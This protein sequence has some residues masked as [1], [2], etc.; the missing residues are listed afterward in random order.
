M[1]EVIKGAPHLPHPAF[2][3]DGNEIDGIYISKFQN[4]LCE[5][6][7]YALPDEDP[8]TGVDFDTAVRACAEKGQ[9]FH[10]MT[11]MEWGAVALWCQANE[12]LPYGNNDAGKDIREQRCAARPT[13]VSNDPPIYRVATGTGPVT[14]SH[15]LRADGIY[16]LNANV[17]E[18][19]GGMR[20][21][22]GELQLLPNALGN[23]AADASDWRAV[24]GTTGALIPPNGMGTTKN[25]I[26]LDRIDDVWIYVTAPVTNADR[27][28]RFCAFDDVRAHESVCEAA[29]QLLYA[30]GILP[31][32]GYTHPEVAFYANNGADERMVFRGGRWGQGLN[33]GVF[34]TC[35]DDPRSYA[36][37]AVGF[38]AAYYEGPLKKGT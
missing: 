30:S 17:W 20:L 11:A 33:A 15:N 36:G 4:V 22:Y 10:L 38:R 21:V 37:P 26:K 14:W 28:A 3:V 35:M 24:D 7:A 1:D 29:K 31:V 9:G 32:P 18:W 34:K 8:A 16:D 2:V 13:C 12:C 27:H 23:Q 5:G 19:S 25:S 6:L